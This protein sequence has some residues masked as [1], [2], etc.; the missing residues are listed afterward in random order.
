MYYTIYKITNLLNEKFYIG[1]HKTKNLN[2]NYMGSGKYLKYAQNKHGIHNFVKEILYVF[3]SAEEMYA[4]EA[5]LVTKAFIAEN[6]TYNIKEGGFGGFD[7]INNQDWVMTD[8][9]INGYKE[10]TLKLS[11]RKNS[12]FSKTLKRCH[13]EGKIRYDGFLGKAHSSETKDKIGKANSKNQSGSSNSQYGTKWITNGKENKKIKSIEM[14]P[15][16]WKAGR[17]IKNN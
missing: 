5:E 7:Y 8:K 3:S 11:G 16:G 1:S 4:K 15:T 14:I 13:A 6:N 10:R 12:L 17:I 9:R 2:D